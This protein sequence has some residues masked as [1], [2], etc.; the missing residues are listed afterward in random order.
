[1]TFPNQTPQVSYAGN[2]ATVTWAFAFEIPFQSDGVTPAIRVFTTLAGVATPLVLGTDYTVAGVGNLTGG[3]I[4]TLG[5]RSPVPTGTTITIQRNLAYDQAFTFP[6]QGY[7]P[8]Y[9][10]QMGDKIAMQLQQL[11][12]RIGN[13]G[14]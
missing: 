14:G 10:E 4:T 5:A 8:T 3:S 7:L 12:M 1:M 6:N 11:A 13:L 2:S 9:I